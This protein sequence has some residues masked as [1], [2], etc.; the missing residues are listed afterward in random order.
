MS[1]CSTR[2]GGTDESE[3]ATGFWVGEGSFCVCEGGKA[4]A[5]TI[6]NI[7]A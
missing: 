6:V 1:E 4:I 7:A 2:V 3:G 5:G